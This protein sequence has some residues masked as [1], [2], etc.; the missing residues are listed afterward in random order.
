LKK[1]QAI[2]AGQAKIYDIALKMQFNDVEIIA[3]RMLDRISE[4]KNEVWKGVLLFAGAALKT[5]AENMGH[6]SGLGAFLSRAGSR[7]LNEGEAEI[8]NACRETY[9]A[10]L[11]LSE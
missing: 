9:F 3:A 8:L 4:E 10:L 2:S 5:A 1:K 6:R 7:T 11:K